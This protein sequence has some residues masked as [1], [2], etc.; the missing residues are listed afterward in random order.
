MPTFDAASLQRVIHLE[1]AAHPEYGFHFK[2]RRAAVEAEV[3]RTV[4]VHVET[5][6]FD[7][8][9]PGGFLHHERP[10]GAVEVM[11]RA[12][13]LSARAAATSWTRHP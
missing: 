8:L 10:P 9:A 12:G 4:R 3:G 5:A 11:A 2:A 13:R 7:M 6:P 1:Y